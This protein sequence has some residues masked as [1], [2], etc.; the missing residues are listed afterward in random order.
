[1]K[2]FITSFVASFIVGFNDAIT[3]G[4]FG[5]V[6][7]MTP[8]FKILGITTDMVVAP[9]SANSGLKQFIFYL[10]GNAATP[11][12]KPS[13]ETIFTAIIA[14]IPTMTWHDRIW[15]FKCLDMMAKS[16]YLM[17]DSIGKQLHEVLLCDYDAD[18]DI[19]IETFLKSKG[20]HSDDRD[21]TIATLAYLGF[22]EVKLRAVS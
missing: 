15:F 13:A 1:M 7:D 3:K 14:Y 5:T 20:V 2:K 12:G 21:M 22:P 8:L 9:S 19:E 18:G 16:G 6:M 4:K 10:V 17:P 11:T